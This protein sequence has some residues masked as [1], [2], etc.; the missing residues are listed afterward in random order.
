MIPNRLII[1][2]NVFDLEGVQNKIKDDRYAEEN[3][4]GEPE[5]TG[6]DI[7]GEVPPEEMPNG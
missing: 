5:D 1:N 6:M 7:G 2:D 4:M 3:M